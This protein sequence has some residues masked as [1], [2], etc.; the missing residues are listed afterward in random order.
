MTRPRQTEGGWPAHAA[1]HGKRITRESLRGYTPQVAR[2]LL[3]A[4][5]VRVDGGTRMSATIVETEAYRGSHDPAS[6]AYRGETARNSVMFGPPGHAYVYFTMGLHYCLNVTTEPEGVAAAVLLRAA[7]PLEGLEE[8]ARRRGTREV[9]RLCKG[10]GNLTRA[11][12]IDGRLNGED[13]V[14]STTLFLEQGPSDP[15]PGVSARVGVTAARSRRWRFY[16]RGNPFVSEERP[17][18]AQNP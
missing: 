11:F 8:M 15:S 16:I 17:P 18:R 3:G 10:P 12:G 1:S 5:L 7:Q 14:E 6:H 2:K 9:R 13:M 4:R